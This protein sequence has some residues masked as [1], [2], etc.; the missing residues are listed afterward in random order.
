MFHLYAREAY[1][2]ERGQTLE[3]LVL[4]TPICKL[5]TGMFPRTGRGI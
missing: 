3:P 2:I 5:S 1:L 4:N